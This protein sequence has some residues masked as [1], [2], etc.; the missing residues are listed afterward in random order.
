MTMSKIKLHGNE[1]TTSGTLPAVGTTAANFTLV[2]KDLSSK[3]LS[4]FKGKNIILNIFPSIDT[5]VCAASVR[6]FNKEAANLHNTEV[7]CISKDLPF[8]QARFCG[9]EGIDRVTMLSDFRTNFAN[10][11]GVQMTDSPMKGLMSRAV[12]VVNP[13]GKVVYTQQVDEITKEPDY[14]SALNAVK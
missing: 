2:T 12:V 3:S 13:E 6:N 4:D 11:Y 8:A 14:Q 10:E 1:V 5:G 9:A 7:L